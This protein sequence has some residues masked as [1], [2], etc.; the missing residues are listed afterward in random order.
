MTRPEKIER[1]LLRFPC[2]YRP[3]KYRMLELT[4]E[5]MATLDNGQPLVLRGSIP[6]KDVA[7][8]T[9]QG[10]TFQL[11]ELHVSNSLLLLAP[12]S[13]PQ[14]DLAQEQDATE[15]KSPDLV[16]Y[17]VKEHLNQIW[18]LHPIS[19]RLE[20]LKTLLSPSAYRGPEAEDAV[21]F[22]PFIYNSYGFILY[23]GLHVAITS[24]LHVARLASQ[25]PS[26][27]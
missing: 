25:R 8:L 14:E 18:E 27:R 21:G 7:V 5:A 20:R 4:P 24:L 6:D 22:A 15:G 12:S 10:Q 13:V 17:D 26:Q 9:T 3:G 11:K 1:A 2:D 23:P 19:P 16:Y